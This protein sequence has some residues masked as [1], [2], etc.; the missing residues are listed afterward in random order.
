MQPTE[1]R[2]ALDPAIV[3]R[4]QDRMR[5]NHGTPYQFHW[6]S[7]E[8][9]SKKFGFVQQD[10]P[11]V[12]K[13]IETGDS[14]AALSYVIGAPF[15]DPGR[16]VSSARPAQ[17]EPAQPEQPKQP[18]PG[19]RTVSILT[20]IATKI[21]G[22]SALGVGLVTSIY[23]HLPSRHTVF[24]NCSFAVVYVVVWSLAALVCGLLALSAYQVVQCVLAVDVWWAWTSVQRLVFTGVDL[25]VCV[26]ASINA[27][28]A[29]IPSGLCG[30]WT[31]LLGGARDAWTWT[32]SPA[33]NSTRVIVT[34]PLHVRVG[35]MDSFVGFH[36]GQ[37]LLTLSRN[38]GVHAT[39]R[40]TMPLRTLT[41]SAWLEAHDADL[42]SL[43]SQLV[44]TRRESA[45]L[46]GSVQTLTARL[47]TVRQESAARSTQLDAG[48]SGLRQESAALST[49]LDAELSVLRREVRDLQERLA[50][51]GK[52]QALRG[53]LDQGAVLLASVAALLGSAGAAS[54]AGAVSYWMMAKAGLDF[55]AAVLCEYG[56]LHVLLE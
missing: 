4:L 52:R 16:P 13:I 10:I 45:S 20:D 6:L 37:S 1:P 23:Y 46:K 34:T 28:F 15:R 14:A 7:L 49:Q 40:S 11:L 35:R 42:E 3:S 32:V 54:A 9:I 26:H 17:P 8:T 41:L 33:R 47:A 25:V 21:L 18:K 48:L 29:S 36:T 12:Q 2:Y 19:R 44:E 5:E 55:V 56:A 22:V 31:T 24:R 53:K 38:S 43:A 39:N 51:Q 27:F 30:V 50:E